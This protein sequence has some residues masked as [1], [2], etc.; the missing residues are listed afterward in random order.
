ML[1]IDFVAGSARDPESTSSYDAIAIRVKEAVDSEQKVIVIDGGFSDVGD[2]IVNVVNEYYGTNVVDVMISTHPDKDHLNGLVT[3]I[4]QLDVKELWVHQPDQYKDD[5]SDFSNI[6]NL[7]TLLAFAT[8]KGVIVKD[9]YTG[10]SQLD[11]RLMVLGPTEDYYKQLLD[12]QLNPEV[13]A[14]FANR[15]NTNRIR[16]ALFGAVDRFA[17]LTHLPIETL[18]DGNKTQPRN[19]SSVITLLR[20]NS[21]AYLFTGD[22]GIPAL[23]FAADEYEALTGGFDLAPLSFFQ[24][25]HH[26]SRH[27]LGKTVLSRI[28]GHPDQPYNPEVRVYIHAAGAST[29]HPSPKVTNALMRRGCDPTHL[30]VTNGSSKHHHH[31]SD[32]RGWGSVGPYPILEEE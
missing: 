24:A 9:P 26:G 31:N 25:P 4:Q 28:L 5:L 15:G 6:D 13:Q 10:V 29:K 21:R 32:D 8:E 3:A 18:G 11:G 27:N 14:F 22:A 19:N 16:E 17:A 12:E 23:E 1:D 30:V 2:D 20:Y 7:R